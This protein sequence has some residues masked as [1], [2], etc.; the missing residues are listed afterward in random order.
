MKVE[1]VKPEMVSLKKHPDIN[2]KWLQ[3]RIEEDT[4]I[5][6]LGELIVYQRERK[7]SS[8]G[9]I[10][11]LLVDTETQTMYETEVMLGVLDESHIIRAIEYWDI[12][13]RRFPS[14][15]HIA[16]IVAEEITN[17]FFNVISL[18]NRTVPII[19]I[20]ISAI[21]YDSKLMVN[22]TKVLD[23]YEEPE[24]EDT[25]ASEITDRTY[26]ESRVNK[27][28]LAVF[29]Q[30]I[31]TIENLGLSPRVTYNK[32]HISLGTSRKNFAWFH[33]RKKE[34][35]CHVDI[36]VGDE[37]VET[38]KEMMDSSGISINKKMWKD[39]YALKIHLADAKDSEPLRE[40]LTLA[41][42]AYD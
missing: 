41:W 20:Q 30:V 22:F 24:E 25:E 10:D 1:Y 5:L 21:M 8:G 27:K 17:R 28:S 15:N 36:R 38:V 33:P 37:N 26:W 19:A 16:V 13:R 6:G 7:Q 31:Q 14:K 29:D 23:V 42:K 32:G 18:L 9:R 39:S 12:E 34:Q 40:V 2:E 4:S 3:D 35:Y 11:L